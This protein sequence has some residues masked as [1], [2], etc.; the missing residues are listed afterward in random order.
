MLFFSQ[1][2]LDFDITRYLQNKIYKMAYNKKFTSNGLIDYIYNKE[3][4]QSR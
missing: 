4:D 1:H 3:Y 2:G